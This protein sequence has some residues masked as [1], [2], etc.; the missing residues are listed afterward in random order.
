[1]N[2]TCRKKNLHIIIR[3]YLK[4]T[5]LFLSLMVF[6][7][8]FPCF[9]IF[10]K[11]KLK[12]IENT[13]LMLLKIEHVGL[14]SLELSWKKVVYFSIFFFNVPSFLESNCLNTCNHTL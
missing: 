12:N 1:M 5:L 6:S 13:F 10:L 3:F 7:N 11:T 8:H 9:P 4:L 14:V 2:G